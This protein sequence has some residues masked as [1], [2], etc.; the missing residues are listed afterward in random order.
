MELN[1]LLGAAGPHE[2]SSLPRVR[3]PNVE[4]L[5]DQWPNPGKKHLF[6][7]IGFLALRLKRMD[8][9]LETIA[10]L[11]K[12]ARP[13]VPAKRTIMMDYLHRVLTACAT[14]D[15]S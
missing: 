9:L 3:N 12:D 14:I 13:F 2:Q 10:L 7:L 8:S 4:T 11:E 6:L 1:S 5:L 15:Q